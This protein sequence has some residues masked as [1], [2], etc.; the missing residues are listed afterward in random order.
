MLLTLET[1][2]K[3]LTSTHY[4]S[5]NFHIVFILLGMLSLLLG[6]LAGVLISLVYIFPDLFDEFFSFPQLRPMHTTFVISWVI[7]TVTGCIY[8]YIT[9]VENIKIFSIILGKIHLLVFSLTGLGILVSFFVG[10]MG[11]REY[12]EF[13]PLLT[14]PILL[15]WVLFGFNYFTTLLSKFKSWPV[16]YWMWGVGIIFMTYHLA[17]SHF[18]I[19]SS[20]RND[21]IKDFGVQ[22]KSYG[23]FVGSWN[24]LVYGTAIFLMTKVKDDVNVAYGKKTFFFFFLGLINLMFGWAHHT[25]ILPISPWIRYLAYVT[26]M[27]EWIVFI[28]PLHV[29]KT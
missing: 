11:G 25:Y 26:S 6:S 21:F 5:F 27:T 18:W 1:K 13:F 20:F 24:M 17:E 22:W 10:R 12:L 2:F 29:T 4:T 14:I 8:Y 23:S 9:K 7:L 16:Y 15:G 3:T 19:F 28:F